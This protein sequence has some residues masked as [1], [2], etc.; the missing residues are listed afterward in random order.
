MEMGG[1][2]TPTTEA[3]EPQFDEAMVQL[4][5]ERF[6]SEQNL[7]GGIVAGL[8]AAVVGAAAWA[9]VTVVSGYQ[10]GLM[11]IA[12]GCLV[13]Y[14][15]RV[16]G[17]GIDT[18]FGVAGAVLALFGCLLGNALTLV[19]FVAQAEGLTYFETLARINYAA[20]PELM[21]ATF[22]P[23]DLV[24]YGIAVYEGYKFALRQI[25][26]D[27]LEQAITGAPDPT[28]IG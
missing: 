14:A 19:H 13:G 8:V 1:A 9:A 24:F 20:M 23:F 22:D 28:P 10:L 3:E 27:E 4:A 15:V 12:V 26:E 6:R 25:G 2:G 16:V 21:V 11:A 7:A 17:K 18:A 5:M